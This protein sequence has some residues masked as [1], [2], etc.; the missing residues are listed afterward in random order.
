MIDDAIK[1]KE[2]INK[3]KTDSIKDDADFGKSEKVSEPPSIA[4]RQ[5]KDSKSKDKKKMFSSFFSSGSKSKSKNKDIKPV[6]GDALSTAD[7]NK[8][9]EK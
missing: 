7:Y 9:K 5:S 8:G 2:V 6:G 3:Q 1:V 4:S